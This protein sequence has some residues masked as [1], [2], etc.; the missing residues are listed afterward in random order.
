MFGIMG[1]TKSLGFKNS[2]YY[3]PE[4]FKN[5]NKQLTYG[6]WGVY[7]CVCVGGGLWNQ[8]PVTQAWYIYGRTCKFMHVQYYPQ[9]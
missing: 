2:I 6:G 8:I 4:N 5:K 3:L 1:K 7:V 9:Y